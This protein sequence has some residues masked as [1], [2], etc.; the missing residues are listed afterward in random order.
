M[1]ITVTVLTTGKALG[2][3]LRVGSSVAFPTVG[4]IT[5]TI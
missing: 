1:R 2:D 5:V 4:H 3:L